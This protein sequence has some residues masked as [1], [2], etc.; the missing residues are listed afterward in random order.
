MFKWRRGTKLSIALAAVLLIA[1]GCQNGAPDQQ[2]P[3]SAGGASPAP[4]QTPSGPQTQPQSP[5]PQPAPTGAPPAGSG[6]AGSGNET[7]PAPAVSMGQVTAVRLADAQS[8]W[9]GGDGWIAR[10]D[11]GGRKWTVQYA[12]TGAIRQIFALNGQDA[13]ASTDSLNLLS[14]HDGGKHWAAAGKMANGAFFHFISPSEAFSGNAMTTDG[15][16]SWT[17]L[18]VP[19]HMVGDAYFHDRHNGWAITQDNEAIMVKRTQDGGKT[20]TNVMF[21]KASGPLNGTVIRSAGTDDAWIELIGD[22]GMTQTSYSLFHT[23]DGG[24]HWQT[25]TAKSTAGGGPAPG[26]PADGP[27][28]ADNT[29]SA[30]GALY[31][32]SPEIAYMGGKCQACDKPN[33]IG[34]T[35]DGG[36]TWTNGKEAFAGYGE[37]LLAIADAK[38]G[39]W[40]CTDNAAASVMYVTSDGGAHWTKAHTFDKP[41]QS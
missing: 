37:Q 13:W 26:L 31:V 30:P 10:T 27:K 9:V 23:A 21:A 2:N 32:V 20:W 11:D 12:G 15:G 14:T 7:A 40:I 3:G 22:S 16:K 38:H 4:Q 28:V 5:Q 19:E 18:P 33:T 41:K 29:G 17:A 34:W 1:S 35:T 8:G 39:W 36:K 6:N 25:V 24:K